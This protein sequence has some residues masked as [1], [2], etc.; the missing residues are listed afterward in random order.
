MSSKTNEGCFLIDLYPVFP[1]FAH[2]DAIKIFSQ[3]SSA[4]CTSLHYFC[5]S[6]ISHMLSPH[7]VI[8]LVHLYIILDASFALCLLFSS[9]LPGSQQENGLTHQ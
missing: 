4:S 7:L 3:S 9:L 2:H 5:L 8:L 1:T 6:S